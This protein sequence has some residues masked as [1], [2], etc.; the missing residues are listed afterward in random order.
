MGIRLATAIGQLSLGR[1]KLHAQ[2]VM[3]GSK[4]NRDDLVLPLGPIIDKADTCNT[5]ARRPPLLT[6][7]SCAC[8]VSS[9]HC[10]GFRSSLG[11]Q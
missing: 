9:R 11:L 10:L 7:Q 3:L 8:D 1:L 4:D 5:E 2:S 6:L